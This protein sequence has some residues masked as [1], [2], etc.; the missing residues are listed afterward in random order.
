MVLRFGGGLRVRPLG[1]RRVR[2]RSTRPRGRTHAPPP[3]PPPRCRR[4]GAPGR[5]AELHRPRARVW[6]R[7]GAPNAYTAR[8]VNPPRV[9]RGRT[10]A[11]ARAVDT[12][13]TLF[14]ARDRPYN[15]A[16]LDAEDG[17][18]WVYILPAQ[19]D[20]EVF[21]HG[22][23]VRYLVAPDGTAVVTT[24]EMHR[25]ILDIRMPKDSKPEMGVHVAVVDD[26]PEDSDVFYVLSRKPAIPE[27]I[28]TR[29]FV[30]RVAVT[31]TI[32][33]LGKA[34]DLLERKDP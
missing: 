28:A 9:E 4:P 33:Y 26:A 6:P 10:L 13:R 8:P 18:H 25:T 32:E 11:R 16:V 3:P 5:W 15:V 29:T 21:P 22:G 7:C 12:C 19:T 34:K 17:R 24:R 30:Y 2:R 14:G 20:P 31:G 23:D 1:W 27:M